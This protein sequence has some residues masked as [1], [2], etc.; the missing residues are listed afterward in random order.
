ME[1]TWLWLEE[2]NIADDL[3]EFVQK[4]SSEIC[5][6]VLE[7]PGIGIGALSRDL[8]ISAS[9]MK[10]ALN[11]DLHYYSCKRHRGQLLTEY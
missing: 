4:N 2:S 5:R 1:T 8:I 3:I 9:T 6:K 10:L 11:D 7:D